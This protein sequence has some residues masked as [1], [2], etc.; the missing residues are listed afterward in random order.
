MRHGRYRK[1]QVSSIIRLDVIPQRINSRYPLNQLNVI[2]TLPHATVVV[3]HLHDSR[4]V[5]KNPVGEIGREPKAVRR[6]LGLETRRATSRV[7]ALLFQ[8]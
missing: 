5:L 3:A 2:A 1:Y 4:Y 8:M 6:C 7:V